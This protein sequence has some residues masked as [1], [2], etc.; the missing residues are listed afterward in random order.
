MGEKMKLLT[1]LILASS[2]AFAQKPSIFVVGPPES[3][4][5]NTHFTQ[6]VMTQPAILGVTDGPSWASVETTTAGA[7]T[8]P[9]AP[10]GTDICQQNPMFPTLYHTYNWT[11]ADATLAQWLATGSGWGTKKVNILTTSQTN[12]PN[13]AT[14]YYLTTLTYAAVAGTQHYINVAKDSCSQDAGVAITSAARLTGGSNVVTVTQNN[15]YNGGDVIWIYGFTDSTFNITTQAGTP[16]LSA[17]ATSWTYASGATNAVTATGSGFS[18]SQV[19]SWFVPTDA[20]YTAAQEA[21]EAALVYHFNHSA[22]LSQIGYSRGLPAARGGEVVMLCPNQMVANGFPGYASQAQAKTTWL[23]WIQNSINYMATLN[24]TFQVI[25]SMNPGWTTSSPDYSYAD[26][27]AG[28]AIAATNAGGHRNGF[29]SQGL[30]QADQCSTIP[31][32]PYSSADWVTSANNY[33]S[34]GVLSPGTQP[35]EGQTIDC[36]D[37]TEVFDVPSCSWISGLQ[38]VACFQQNQ[39]TPSSKSKTGS[40][41]TYLAYAK[42]KHLSTLELY[43][44]DAAI[45][46]DPTYCNENSGAC[47]AGSYPGAIYGMRCQGPLSATL[48]LCPGGH[49]DG[50][51]AAALNTFATSTNVPG[52]ISAGV[53]KTRGTATR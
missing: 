39:G 41:V 47:G 15:S 46:F 20:G 3:G 12:G 40:L 38:G 14:P 31:P 19:Q 50:T 43:A 22:S 37:P 1:F 5:A 18:E 29:G 53:T 9:C 45:A 44:G 25:N 49:G 33:F 6:Y 30:Q 21:F 28:Y 34:S 36:S 23:A 8:T 48:P 2:L 52:Q 13:S 10:L 11:S 26:A 17:N 24:P 16:V 51:Y 27:Q 32:P 42:L 4:T 7:L 35:I